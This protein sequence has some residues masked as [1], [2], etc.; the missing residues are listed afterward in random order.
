MITMKDFIAEED[1][2]LREHAEEVTFPLSEE[3]KTLIDEMRTF[4]INS[5]TPE[6]A[7]EYGLRAG[8]GVAAPQLGIN[9]QIFA[10]YLTEL[11]EEGEVVDTIIDEIFINPKI[12]RHSVKQAAL[13][14][15]EGCLSVRR[16][17]PGLVPRPRRV[18][19]T[20]QDPEG[21]EYEVKLRDYEA[22]V[23]QHELDHLKGI[24]FYDHINDQ[25]PW[26]ADDNTVV[27]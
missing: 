6:I 10:V 11:D 5:Q 15:G 27:L 12:T 24:L 16:S 9:K 20:Y 23:V 17:V 25:N 21:D 13:P 19:L 14:E 22:I 7:E 18:T 3:E 8:V 2:R 26:Q 1:P 4:L